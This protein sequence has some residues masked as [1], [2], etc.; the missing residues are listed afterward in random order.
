MLHGFLDRSRLS[1]DRIIKFQPSIFLTSGSTRRAAQAI[2]LVKRSFCER[3][4]CAV[5]TKS[6]AIYICCPGTNENDLRQLCDELDQK[7]NRLQE[8]PLTGKMVD[9]IL[10]ISAMERRRWTKDGRLASAGHTLFGNGGKR[11]QLFAYA[12]ATIMELAR[13]SHHVDA[14]RGAD[15][16]R[17][18]GQKTRIKFHCGR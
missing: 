13:A 15:R 9:E 6:E 11:V 14:W 17:P 10:S 2:R 7:L 8:E 18:D 5:E 16:E 4:D 12:P 3:F 1:N